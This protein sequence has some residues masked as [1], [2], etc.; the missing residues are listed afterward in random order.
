M[1]QTE[2]NGFAEI[3]TGGGCTALVRVEHDGTEILITKVGDAVA[4][5]SLAGPVLV[6]VMDCNGLS[7]FTK[8]Y[9]TLVAAYEDIESGLG[10]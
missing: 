8:E 6:G 9:A 3:G 1:K 5:E 4:P 7:V 10:R 2:K